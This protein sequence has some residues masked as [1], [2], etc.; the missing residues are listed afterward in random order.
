M[1]QCKPL[2]R[3]CLEAM[4]QQRGLGVQHSDH[5]DGEDGRLAAWILLAVGVEVAQYRAGVRGCGGGAQAVA[6]QVEIESK[7]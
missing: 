4:L 7:F 2:V 1:D 3:P 6:A 5:A